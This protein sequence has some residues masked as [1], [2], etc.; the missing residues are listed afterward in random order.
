MP[1]PRGLPGPQGIRGEPGAVGPPGS[2]GERVRV[3]FL[4]CLY[5]WI[6]P[7]MFLTL[8]DS[9]ICDVFL[10]QGYTG[11]RGEKGDKGASGER[12]KDGSP[13]SVPFYWP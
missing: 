10:S 4:K 3:E 1:G 2:L 9:L 6:L 8:A 13:V 11:A 12:G 7:Y 5:V